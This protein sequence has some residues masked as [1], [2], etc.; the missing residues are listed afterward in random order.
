MLLL[1]PSRLLVAATVLD[2][3]LA[4]CFA[5]AVLL[6]AALVISTVLRLYVLCLHCIKHCSCKRCYE[7]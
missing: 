5:Y 4:A 3:S 2:A 6:L 7:G 1:G